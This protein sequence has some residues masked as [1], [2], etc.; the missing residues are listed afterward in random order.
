[1]MDHLRAL[2]SCVFIR[3]HSNVLHILDCGMADLMGKLLCM[4]HVDCFMQ[5]TLVSA[6]LG[7]RIPNYGPVFSASERWLWRS[8]NGLKAWFTLDSTLPFCLSKQHSL[9]LTE[10]LCM[11]LVWCSDMAV[12]YFS[13]FTENIKLRKEKWLSQGHTAILGRARTPCPHRSSM[14]SVALALQG[15]HALCHGPISVLPQLFW[16]HVL[17][18]DS[19][20]AGGTGAPWPVCWEEALVYTVHLDFS[21]SVL[22]FYWHLGGVPRSLGSRP[23]ARWLWTGLLGKAESICGV[24]FS[25]LERSQQSGRDPGENPD[26]WKDVKFEARWQ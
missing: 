23:P 18:P 10:F 9:L 4:Q 15:T 24:C 26:H 17:F 7:V 25:L 2:K 19:P 22:D 3:L 6:A 5:M 21:P 1:M 8:A 11:H 12:F 20:R 13:Y 14:P 16:L